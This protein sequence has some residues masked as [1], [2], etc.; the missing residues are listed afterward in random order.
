VRNSQLYA[1]LLAI[2]VAPRMSTL[3]ALACAA[4]YLVCMFAAMLKEAK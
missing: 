2:M 4:F 3:G 1:I